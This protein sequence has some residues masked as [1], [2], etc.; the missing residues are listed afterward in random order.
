M[1][2]VRSFISNIWRALNLIWQ[3]SRRLTLASLV[4]VFVQSLLPLAG[5]YIMKMVVD[6]VATNRQFNFERVAILISLS[7]IIALFEILCSS[8]AE[9]IR[10]AQSRAITDHMHDILQAKSIEVD[11]EYY[12]NSRYYDT[13]HRAQQ[14]SSI[15]PNRI[16]VN[17]LQIAQNGISLVTMV[18][19]IISIHWSLAIFLIVAAVPGLWVQ[20]TH[21]GKLFSWEREQTHLER[22]G[23]YMSDLLTRDSHAKEIRLF[24]LAPLF[25]DRFRLVREKL[26]SEKLNLLRRRAIGQGIGNAL[27][28]IM[29]FTA[30]GYTAYR[31]LQGVV[32][33]GDLVLFYQAVQ[34]ARAYADQFLT[35]VATLYENNLYLFNLYEFLDLKPKIR[36]PLCPKLVPRPVRME[37]A[38][39]HV[40]F[41]YPSG[42]KRVLD[43]INL[44][45]RPGE[46][47]A[48]VGEN[49]AGKTTL[50]KLLCRLYDVTEGTITVDGIDLRNF[51]LADLRKQISV[52]FQDYGRYQVTARDNVWFGDTDLPPNHGR[53]FEAARQA[54]V[55]DVI[56]NLRNGYESILGKWFDNGEELS[57]GEWQKIALAR[58]FL[59]QAQIII[60]DEP[61]SFMDAK[62]EFELFE[63][64]H[65]LTKSHTAILISHR[66]STVKMA[67]TIY[68]LEHGRIVESGTHDQ[69]VYRGGKYASLFETQAQYYR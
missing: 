49:G 8:I 41:R 43:D 62:A 28:T 24:N 63:R 56:T 20:L 59:R 36:E 55:H 6:A 14:E 12:E 46:H 64:F 53:I 21:A 17:L 32:T 35:S 7:A 3:C 54:G 60:L 65:Q 29:A 40:G 15:R 57:I 23:W 44:T 16:L 42:G 39:N 22:Q 18:G 47:I 19:L 34:R 2:S 4:L 50:I 37:I 48:L 30:Y 38:F 68:V 69:L 5:L 26:G 11:L 45:V 58:A 13:L 67:D 51:Y 10:A 1:T 31:A 27:A 52:V 25:I 61:T 66:L 9:I 33:V